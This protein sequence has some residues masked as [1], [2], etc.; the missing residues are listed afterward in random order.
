[1][2]HQVF[3][4]AQLARAREQPS[5]LTHAAKDTADVRK[6]NSPGPFDAADVMKPLSE[7]FFALLAFQDDAK[8]WAQQ[9]G[10][11]IKP[12]TFRGLM[13]HRALEPDAAVCDTS[14][15]LNAK[16]R[17]GSLLLWA[18]AV[19][20]FLGV[21]IT[22][23]KTDFKGFKIR[24]KSKLAAAAH[25][26]QSPRDEEKGISVDNA[27]APH[28]PPPLLHDGEDDLTAKVLLHPE[29][30]PALSNAHIGQPFL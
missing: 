5:P 16:V 13:K 1:M 29:D 27:P 30:P 26:R 22:R 4:M 10:H 28:R 3:S 17:G 2:Q 9:D 11:R 21:H 24:A 12:V 18:D 25:Y 19:I 23:I 15:C 14:Q 8:Q 7:G 20:T 6:E